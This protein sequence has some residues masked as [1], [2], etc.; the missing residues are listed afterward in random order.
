MRELGD[1]VALEAASSVLNAAREEAQR[2]VEELSRELEAARR[3]L[4]ALE[5]QSESE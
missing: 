3:A 1:D 2:R 4:A 5:G